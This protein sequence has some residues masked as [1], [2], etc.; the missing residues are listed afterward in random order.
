VVN[1]KIMVFWVVTLCSLV[2]TCQCL[3]KTC[4]LCV[5]GWMSYIFHLFY[6]GLKAAGSSEM[7]SSV[8]QSTLHHIPEDLSLSNISFSKSF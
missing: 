5:Q 6:P 3:R 8:N 4:C 1:I 7:M 2:A